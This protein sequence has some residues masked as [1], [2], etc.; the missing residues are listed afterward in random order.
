ME[1]TSTVVIRPAEVSDAKKI[2]ILLKTVYI[3]TYGIEGVSDEYVNFIEE[4]FSIE[5][6]SKKIFLET[7]IYLVADYKN[8]L[9]GVAEIIKNSENPIDCLHYPELSKLY[10]LDGF[11][12]KKVGSLLIDETEK[13]LLKSN[14]LS[15][16]LCVWALNPA[17]ISFYEKKSFE[18]MGKVPFQME[19]NCY[20]N[21]V[22]TKKLQP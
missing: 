5:K 11:K 6:I 20:E 4:E 7:S 19:T 18:I 2:S 1:N 9:L 13:I 10:V 16:W 17:A 21:L 14:L 15:Y 12:R 3:H 8:N 22:M